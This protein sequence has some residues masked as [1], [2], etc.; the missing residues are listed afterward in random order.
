MM[1]KATSC[2]KSRRTVA[3]G[4]AQLINRCPYCKYAPDGTLVKYCIDCHDEVYQPDDAFYD[5]AL[6]KAACETC[7]ARTYGESNLCF[8]HW[9]N[10]TAGRG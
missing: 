2:N 9:V 4:R 5:L 6:G 7:G 1:K 10:A 3:Q 8:I